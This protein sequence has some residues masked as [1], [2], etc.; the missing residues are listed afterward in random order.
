M[1]AM[2]L[3]LS[4]APR[5]P[6]LNNIPL[7][8]TP[9]GTSK[10]I[11]ANP[12]INPP[13]ISV[14]DKPTQQSIVKALT[15][16]EEKPVPVE[17]S[18]S[19]A[20]TGSYPVEPPDKEPEALPSPAQAPPIVSP[21]RVWTREGMIPLLA[22]YYDDTAPFNPDRTLVD[23]DNWAR[24]Q[25]EVPS[26]LKVLE[27]LKNSKQ[28]RLAVDE[29][30]A[31][32]NAE[33]VTALSPRVPDSVVT[34]EED[35]PVAAVP[36][37]AEP[38]DALPVEPPNKMLVAEEIY[39]GTVLKDQPTEVMAEAEAAALDDAPLAEAKLTA[40]DAAEPGPGVS[41]TVVTS[42]PD[43]PVVVAPP[44]PEPADAVPAELPY[45]AP[46]PEDVPLR[47]TPEDEPAQIVAETEAVAAESSTSVDDV[48]IAAPPEVRA[49]EIPA[50]AIEPAAPQYL[51]SIASPLP[52]LDL[53]ASTAIEEPEMGEIEPAIAAALPETKPLTDE[54][55]KPEAA[56]ETLADPDNPPTE[57]AKEIPMATKPEK[58][59]T[60]SL[61]RKKSLKAKPIV[62]TME[63]ML[64]CLDKFFRDTAK[65]EADMYF[66]PYPE[67]AS[68]RQAP[69]KDEVF[70]E[71]KTL[72]RL[73]K[74]VLEFRSRP[75]LPT[76][77]ISPE[78]MV[79]RRNKE[80]PAGSK[81]GPASD[82]A[83]SA[84]EPQNDLQQLPISP[85][86]GIHG[87]APDVSPQ[88]ILSKAYPFLGDCIV[89]K[90]SVT[91]ENYESWAIGKDVPDLPT[92]LAGLGSWENACGL[93]V[94]EA[95]S[96]GDRR[97]LIALKMFQ[98]AALSLLTTASDLS[99]AHVASTRVNGVL[100]GGAFL[101]PNGHH[102]VESPLE[103][104]PRRQHHGVAPRS[105]PGFC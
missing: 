62:W 78:I 28:I 97:I 75:S 70:E 3:P 88:K 43:V 71:F 81:K 39:L 19:A 29:S 15:A 32:Q 95:I 6:S 82:P 98:L 66:Y 105:Q 92:V 35:A 45:Q 42:E 1:A 58:N 48:E 96:A 54:L 67:W 10:C 56:I 11:D 31:K 2:A 8:L 79:P 74:A 103:G 52:T 64:P 33:K 57:I 60:A 40:R 12:V 50:D 36:A 23:Y 13:Q 41:D 104:F 30:R 18:S 68:S 72:P 4:R 59:D 69:S 87:E 38:T 101:H 53:D 20:G 76:A 47:V 26:R 7:R 46:A 49:S 9:E 94:Q 14:A 85:P 89:S 86:N 51:A 77:E 73:R 61:A 21:G 5:A 84:D 91:A 27:V 37:E 80:T 17:F 102:H 90:S 16:P 22:Q 93:M 25:G 100:G 34:L 44:Q 55:S 83:F 63:N 65:T 24:E 99:A